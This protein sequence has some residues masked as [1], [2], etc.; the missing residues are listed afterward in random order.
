VIQLEK[1][2]A[3]AKEMI[4][5]ALSEKAVS[6][7]TCKRWFQSNEHLKT[8]HPCKK[9]VAMHLIGSEGCDPL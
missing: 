9:G 3:E 7:S 8:E 6:Y 4:C 1:N 2:V 5:S